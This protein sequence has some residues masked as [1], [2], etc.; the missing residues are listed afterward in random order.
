M[1]GCDTFSLSPDYVT[2]GKGITSGYFP[3]S[4]IAIGAELY[5]DLELGSDNAGTLAH[6][7][8]F[9]AHPVGAAAALAVL[10]IIEH[11]NLIEHA[12]GMGEKLSAGLQ[13]FIDHPIVGD[14]RCLGL[15]GSL[16][17]LCRDDA[18]SPVNDEASAN[19][20]AYKVHQSFLNEGV[21]SR[22]AGRSIVLAPPLIVQ[23][24]EI[25]EICRRLG[26]ALDAAST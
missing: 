5:K 13:D 18:D 21:V 20:T 12:R 6:A 17:F 11:D 4:A 9:A 8:T 14:V 15:A 19:E 25:N 22:P 10:E 3:L 16:D 23:E 2:I 1:F 7:S 26:R 24:S